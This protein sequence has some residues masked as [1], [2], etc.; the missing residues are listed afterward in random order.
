MRAQRVWIPAVPE[1]SVEWVH[2]VQ[3]L[4]SD[5]H[6]PD[7]RK[8]VIG[9]KVQDT[10]LLVRSELRHFGDFICEWFCLTVQI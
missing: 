3:K 10:T 6:F 9:E 5:F 1:F 2:P 4:A 7:F 8:H